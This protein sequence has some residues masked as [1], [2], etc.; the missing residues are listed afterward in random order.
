MPA[1][2][3]NL[4][5]DPKFDAAAIIVLWVVYIIGKNFEPTVDFHLVPLAAPLRIPVWWIVIGS[6]IF[7]CLATIAV[8]YSWR[9]KRSSKP[10]SDS[11]TAAVSSSTLT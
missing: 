3:K 5:K 10:I 9:R 1:F 6:A 2:L 7:G 11:S 4:L 8:Q